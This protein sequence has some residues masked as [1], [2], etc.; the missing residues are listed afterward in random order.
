VIFWAP[1]LTYRS[2]QKEGFVRGATAAVIGFDLDLVVRYRI[3]M[4]RLFTLGLG[5]R[6]LLAVPALFAADDLA[7]LR[8]RADAG[9]PVAQ[10]SL[11]VLYTSGQGVPKDLAE[12]VK[13]FRKAAEQNFDIAQCNLGLAYA[14]GEGVAKDPVEAVNW[15]R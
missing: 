10:C 15:Y 3:G 13:W 4:K 2:R 14:K 7:A 12:A 6:M 1:L 5:L 9:E 11:G 8:A